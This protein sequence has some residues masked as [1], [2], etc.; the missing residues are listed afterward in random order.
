MEKLAILATLEKEL[1]MPYVSAFERIAQARR[2]SELLIRIL[3]RQCG[4][5]P[6]RLR[7]Q[8]EQLSESAANNLCDV[9]GEMHS[10]RDLEDWL[11]ESARDS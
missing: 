3:N 4:R 10:L 11:S 7:K 2:Q 9:F 6:A 5:L 8:V 1:E